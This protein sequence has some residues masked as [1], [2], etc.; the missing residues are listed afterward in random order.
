[1]EAK[2]E[3]EVEIEVGL[4]VGVG[5]ESRAVDGVKMV[6]VMVWYSKA[7]QEGQV[8][9]MNASL[10][11]MQQSVPPQVYP[12]KCPQC[13]QTHLLQTLFLA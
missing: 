11:A 8:I 2:V 7:R 5:A 1:M 10:R 9:G 13:I 3:G 12:L 4:G 6:M